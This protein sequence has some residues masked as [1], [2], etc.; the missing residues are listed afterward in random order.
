ME[1]NA[2]KKEL[3]E[4]LGRADGKF[5]IMMSGCTREPYVQCDEETFDD[6]T[7]VF[8][9]EGLAKKKAGE[10]AAAQIPVT[11]AVL[12]SQQMLMF[13][14]S[15]F[16]MG[17]NALRIDTPQESFCVQIDEIV[18]KRNPEEM[19]EG[20]V[21]VENPQLHLTALYFAQELRRPAVQERAGRLRELQEE[22]AA[23][24]QRG[25]YLFALDKE[26]D[27]TPMVKLP[28][29]KRY[30]MVFTDALEFR[31]FNREDK[32]RPVVV[33][34]KNLLKV[35]DKDADGVII[36]FMGVNLPLAIERPETEK[37]DAAC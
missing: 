33:E 15:L 21:W 5:Y 29:E 7:P 36:N 12:E 20:A 22:L 24:F 34:A 32:F 25:T 19:P 11:V 18:K 31:R 16:T 17:I 6:E 2:G 35:L 23:D 13:F 9:E 30:Q 4:R 3:L 14:S 1:I 37:E 27:K 26:A 8:F 10:L 28:N